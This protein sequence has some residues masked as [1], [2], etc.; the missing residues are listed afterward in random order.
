MG[1]AV[2]VV[3][4]VAALAFWIPSRRRKRAQQKPEIATAT[5]AA[6]TTT[7]APPPLT[8]DPPSEMQGEAE[9]RAAVE[10]SADNYYTLIAPPG[11]HEMGVDRNQ[12]TELPT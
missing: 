7:D 2:G 5:A 4:L 11:R 10:A 1:V 12:R 6:G 8:P 3:L 9:K